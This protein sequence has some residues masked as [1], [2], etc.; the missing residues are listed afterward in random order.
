MIEL[1]S[2]TFTKPT[3]GMLQAMM[4]AEV[5][6]DVFG[7]DPSV[8]ALEAEMADFFGMEAGL[9]CPSGTMSNQIAIKVHTQPADE[10]ICDE[11]SHVYQY[12]GGGIAFNAGCSVRLLQG[13]R[14]RLTAAQVTNAINPYDIHK[15]VSRLVVL[16]NT[17]NRGGGSCYAI[18]EIAAIQQVCLE[19][20]LGLHLDGARLWNALVATRQ[21]AK[22]YGT[23]FHSISVCMS[24]GMGA[25]VGS[26]LLGSTSF[27]AKA[28]RVRKVLGGGMRQ[29]GFLAAA[30]RYALAHHLP[31]LAT[32]HEHARQTADL[33]AT[34][35][36][37]NQ[38][39]DPQTNIVIFEVASPHTAASV[40]AFL[41]QH[42]IYAHALSKQSIRLVFHLGVSSTQVNKLMEV[43]LLYS[44]NNP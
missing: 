1:R 12:E 38:V 26:V 25:P 16:E 22:D 14:G 36:W 37:V 23:L 3:P 27:I 32:D 10:V 7:E 41:Q 30:C 43:L 8:N 33:L 40:I 31:L 34:R 2:D 21:S 6:D 35:P 5:G 20:N 17:S 4:E 11:L 18:E 29:V 39:L 42:G 19:H 44:A 24:K 28:R 9:F 13:N 15:P